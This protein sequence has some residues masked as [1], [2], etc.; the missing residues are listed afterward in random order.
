MNNELND[1]SVDDDVW[2]KIASLTVERTPLGAQGAR[3]LRRMHPRKYNKT[4]AATGPGIASSR[5]A[6]GSSGIANAGIR[7]S[8]DRS[9]RGLIGTNGS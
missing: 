1:D 2:T 8:R 9:Y 7:Y 3:R 4:A 6:I 5:R